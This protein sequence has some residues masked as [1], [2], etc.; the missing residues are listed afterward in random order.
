MSDQPIFIY[1]AAGY[2]SGLKITP[3]RV[4]VGVEKLREKLLEMHEFPVKTRALPYD[5]RVY[6][7]SFDKAPKKLSD[8]KI[9]E[10]L[11][12]GS[13]PV[14]E[15]RVAP[16]EYTRGSKMLYTDLCDA[17]DGDV[18][19]VLYTTSGIASSP[20]P[21]INSPHTI[22]RSHGQST[23][24]VPVWILTDLHNRV[25]AEAFQQAEGCRERDCVAIDADGMQ[26]YKAI[27]SRFP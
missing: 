9:L 23:P 5:A 8:V 18:V 13:S 15:R 17:R 7:L 6:L 24:K 2:S 20:T 14:T 4:C 26:L 21:L 27:V 12:V 1:S 25:Y 10:Y 3:I 22:R 19:W 16:L 11:G